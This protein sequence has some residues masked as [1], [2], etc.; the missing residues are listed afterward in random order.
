MHL[1]INAGINSFNLIW[2][3]YAGIEYQTYYIYRRQLPDGFQVLDSVPNS[4]HSYSDI[5]PPQGTLDYMIEIRNENGCNPG[6][7]QTQY[8]SVFSNIISTNVGTD[9]INLTVNSFLIHP[10]PAEDYLYIT[11]NLN[12]KS[13]IDLFLYDLQGRIIIQDRFTSEKIISVKDLNPGVYF[14][15]ITQGS[16]TEY[17]RVIVK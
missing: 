2:T 17:Q 12:A 8:S 6:K 7:D 1:S 10:N 9:D 13:L 14:L 4:I 5:N 3:P 16:Y 11:S 15:V